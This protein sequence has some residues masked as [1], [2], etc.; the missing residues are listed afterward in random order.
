MR[1]MM[2]NSKKRFAQGERHCLRRFQSHYQGIWEARS[3]CGSDGI[4]L[5]GSRVR[6]GQSR[7]GDGN[8]IA[9]MFASGQF[10]DHTAVFG[11]QLDLRGN[12][13]GQHAA[14]VNHSGAGFI[15]GCLKCEEH[16]AGDYSTPGATMD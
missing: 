6:L 14:I 9:Q 4:K 13:G 8:Q 10:G 5:V 15:T 16:L 1:F 2:M 11:V 12:N 7:G 3:P